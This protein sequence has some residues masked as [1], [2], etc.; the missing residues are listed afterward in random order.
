MSQFSLKEPPELKLM[1]EV[2]PTTL[3]WANT[4]DETAIPRWWPI[5][6]IKLSLGPEWIWGCII[7]SKLKLF[8][9]T[10]EIIEW[11]LG[12]SCRAVVLLAKRQ[13]VGKEMWNRCP[14][15]DKDPNPTRISRWWEL[16]V[17][18]LNKS[19]SVLEN[20]VPQWRWKKDPKIEANA[21]SVRIAERARSWLLIKVP[22]LNQM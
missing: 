2:G 22:W 3:E 17:D 14:L 8:S 4:S 1:N 20:E 7:W 11:G 9:W 19:L 5:E 10:K 13:W 6:S 15:Q 16:T 18:S 21:N 12:K